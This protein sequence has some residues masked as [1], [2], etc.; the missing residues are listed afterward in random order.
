MEKLKQWLAEQLAVEEDQL[1]VTP[2]SGDASF[3]RYYRCQNN[4]PQSA[5]LKEGA[6]GFIAVDAP[7][8]K[9]KNHEFV[10]VAGALA[11]HGV[12]APRVF[13][14]DFRQGFMLLSDLG[15]Q[16][17]LPLLNSDT[18]EHYYRHA[19]HLLQ[20]MQS[21][22]PSAALQ[23][24]SYSRQ[25]LLDEMALFPQW[26]VQKLLAYPIKDSER[27]V[28][29]ECFERLLTNAEEQ[30]QVFVHRDYHSR[31]IMVLADGS[32]ATID[33]QDAVKGPITYDLVSLLRDCYVVWPA[34]R[35]N[36]WAASYADLLRQQGLLLSNNPSQFQRWFDLMGLQRHIKVLGIFARLSLR[37]GK[38]AYLYDLPRVI[39][40][41]L[42]VARHYPEM[43]DFVQWFEQ[44]LSPRITAETWS[45]GLG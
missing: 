5:S 22:K 37:D 40:Y 29:D 33:F 43:A 4:A 24:P 2:L 34:Q 25:L 28:L 14:K 15:D 44:R 12:A 21:I 11:Q 27:R 16:L 8:D 26:F 19:L 36:D 39:K 6:R 45:E 30:P 17:L 35:V 20:K 38:Q 7:P 23:I 41:T 32:L 3:R 9:E 1:S 31:N 42:S 10:A 13:A 18:A